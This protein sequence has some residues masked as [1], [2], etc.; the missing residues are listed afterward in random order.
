M[1]SDGHSQQSQLTAVDRA[2]RL[3]DKLQQVEAIGEGARQAMR[4]ENVTL[5]AREDELLEQVHVVPPF[6]FPVCFPIFC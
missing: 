3:L 2:S 5:A 6:P 1:R 4:H